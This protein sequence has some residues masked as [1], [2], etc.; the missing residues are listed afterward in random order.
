MRRSGVWGATVHVLTG[1]PVGLAGAAMTLP[2][3]LVA[4]VRNEPLRRVVGRRTAT[5][6]RRFAALLEV[7]IPEV[8]GVPALRRQTVFHLL[9]LPVGAA[10]FAI[11]AGAGSAGLGFALIAFQRPAFVA[12]GVALLLVAAFSAYWLA[13]LDIVLARRLLGPNAT[14]ALEARLE[15][16]ARARSQAV[17]AADAER[18][19]IER[20]LHDGTQQRLVALAMTLGMA[21]AELPDGPARDTV[22]QAHRQA[23]AALAELRDF[24]RGLHP[25]VLDDR[26]LDAALSGLVAALPQPV[27]LHVDV[28]GRCPPVIEAIAYFVVSETLTN[29]A[30]HARAGRVE[31]AVVRHRGWLRLTVRDDGVGGAAE[32][33]DGGLRGLA[34]RVASVDGRFRMSSPPGGPTEVEVELPCGS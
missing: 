5:Q 30:R 10:G 14:E 23:K 24:V 25:A 19:R 34:Q 32:R 26:G 2:A 8:D 22:D 7:E 17:A 4:A 12:G 33:S 16:L 15:E 29:V 1:L 9:A 13:R 31:V 28:S 6:R 27:E 11:V 18:R 20:D 3:L 21:R